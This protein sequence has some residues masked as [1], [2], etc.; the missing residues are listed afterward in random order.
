MR[1]WLLGAFLAPGCVPGFLVPSWLL[2]AFLL[3]GCVPGSLVR[4][5]LLGAFLAPGCVPG[6]WVRSLLLGAFLAPGCVPGSWVRSWLLVMRDVR[7]VVAIMTAMRVRDEG[8]RLR[9]RR[10]GVSARTG[11]LELLLAKGLHYTSIFMRRVRILGNQAGAC[12]MMTF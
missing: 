6:S 8:A 9:H 1:S 4:S 11:G 2:G 10:A 3:P 12:T 5:W 7:W